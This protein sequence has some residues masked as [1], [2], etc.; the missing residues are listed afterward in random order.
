MTGSVFIYINID[1]WDHQKR[2]SK[3][4]GPMSANG[5]IYQ[6]PPLPFVSQCQYLPNPPPLASSAL[7]AYDLPPLPKWPKPYHKNTIIRPKL[8]KFVNKNIS[9][10]PFQSIFVSGV[11]I[12]QTPLPPFSADVSICQTPT[13]P[14]VSQCQHLP[15]PHSPLRQLMSA[16]VQPPP[17]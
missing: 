17:L 7:S 4:W 11:I 1:F 2:V 8:T 10:C 12:C 13:P 9:F 6:I 16:L 3:K 14:F 15:D 5:S